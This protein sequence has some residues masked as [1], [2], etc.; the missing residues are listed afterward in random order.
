MYEEEVKKAILDACRA[1]GGQRAF[2]KQRGLSQ[3]WISDYISGHKQI[4]NMSLQTL[5]KFFPDLKLV[6]SAEQKSGLTLADLERRISVLEIE[7]NLE[8]N[9][10]SKSYRR[11]DGASSSANAEKEMDKSQ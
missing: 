10:D 9:A 1:A 6:F 7:R 3:S 11:L 5:H 2:A 8:K 4:R